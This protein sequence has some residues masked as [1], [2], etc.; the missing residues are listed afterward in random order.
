MARKLRLHIPGDV[1]H[2]M[3]RDNAGQELF[4]SDDDRYHLYRL[5]QQGVDR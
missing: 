5:I 3:L 4:F 1:Y 2:V